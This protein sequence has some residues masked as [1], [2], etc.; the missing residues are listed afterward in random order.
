MHKDSWTGNFARTRL[1]DDFYKAVDVLAALIGG[2]ICKTAALLISNFECE[3]HAHFR[4]NSAL[5]GL[6]EHNGQFAGIGPTIPHLQ[7]IICTN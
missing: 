6:T 4:Q 7:F 2:H 5:R 3:G 1:I